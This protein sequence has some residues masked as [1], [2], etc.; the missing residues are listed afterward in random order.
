MWRNITGLAGKHRIILAS[1]L[2]PSDD[3]TPL[4]ELGIN[5]YT[6]PF[7][8]FYG[9]WNKAPLSLLLKRFMVLCVSILF[10]RPYEIQKYRSHSM[11]RVI[12]ELLRKE[13]IDIIQCEYNLSALNLPKQIRIPRVLVEHDVSMKPY[14][15]FIASSRSIYTR[16]HGLLQS[17]LWE[18]TEPKLCNN[19]NAV[20]TL[21]PED[22]DY[23]QQ[24]GVETRIE[25]IPPPVNVRNVTTTRKSG[26]ICFVGSFNRA[27]NLESLQEILDLIWPEIRALRPDCRL[28]VAG[29]H[30]G[31]KLLSQIENDTRAEYVG[32]VEDIDNFIAECSVFLAPIRLGGGL[33]M[34]ITHALACGTPVV[35]TSVGAEGIPLT[36]DE[37]LIIENDPLKMATLISDLLLSHDKREQ[38]SATS[39]A[40]VKAKFSLDA[41]LEKYEEL[42]RDLLA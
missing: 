7:Q 42:Y 26:D 39:K 24:H 14:R 21:T 3:P 17:W 40:A 37:G 30:L 31:G 32:F 10:I 29:K 38:I 28:R 23:L 36:A 19:F 20:V 5:V 33:K 6:V 34:K 4:A 8:R 41:A 15:R 12:K 1:Y 2:N 25:I 9:P 13:H 35:T 16:I 18:F 27:A 22:R 11:K